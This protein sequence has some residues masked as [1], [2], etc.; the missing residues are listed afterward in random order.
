[1]DEKASTEPRVAD[2]RFTGTAGEYFKIWIVNIALTVLTLG[3]YSAWAKVRKLRYFYTNT[4]IEDGHFDYHAKPVAILVGRLIAVGLLLIYYAMTQYLPLVGLAIIVAVVLAIPLLMVRARVFH[5]RSTS[6]HGLRFDFQRNYKDAFITIYGG[7]LLALVTLGLAAPTALYL[8]N[9]FAA[10]NSAYGKT[11][12]EFNGQQIEF[13]KI[14]WKSVGL[15]LIGIVG[16]LVVSLIVGMLGA[17]VGAGAVAV[18]LQVIIFLPLL[19][20]YL[21]LGIYV[22]VRQRNYVWNTTALGNNRFKSN[23]SVRKM[24]IL[25]L[26]NLFAIVFSL[27][28]AIPWAQIRLAKY[29]AEQTQVHL[30]DDWKRYVASGA[31]DGS[32]LGG[33]IGEAFDVGVELAF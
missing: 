16:Y 14:F 5:L 30:A 11:P 3:I 25:Y 12:F 4:S 1:M 15:G 10:N 19:V 8:R 26:T 23:L 6:Y 7:G 9:K 24:V 27:G 2:I 18:V 28:L 22:Q 17:A 32:S 29:R 31:D 20:F 33:E 13:Y 21:S